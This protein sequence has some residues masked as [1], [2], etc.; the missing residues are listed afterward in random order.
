MNRPRQKRHCTSALYV[1]TFSPPVCD[2]PGRVVLLGDHHERVYELLQQGAPPL[3]EARVHPP[4][5]VEDV[6][7]QL[8]LAL[9]LR[10]R[11]RRRRRRP[12]VRPGGRGGGGGGRPRRVQVHQVMHDVDQDVV[13][14]VEDLVEVEEHLLQVVDAVAVSLAHLLAGVAVAGGA[15]LGALLLRTTEKAHRDVQQTKL[16]TNALPNKELN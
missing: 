14:R 8:H 9:L 3:G 16:K 7:A 2:P 1:I 12:P 5:D 11:Q 13:V 6:E 15:E 4:E 10:P